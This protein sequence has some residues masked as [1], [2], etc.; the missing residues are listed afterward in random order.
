MAQRATSLGPKPSLFVF[1]VFLCLFFVLFFGCLIQN[2]KPCFSPRKGLFYL[3]SVFLFLSPLCPFGPP[4][5]SVSLSQ[6]LFFLLFFLSSFL[7][8]VLAFFWFLVFVSFFF[9]LSFFLF[10][11]CFSFMKGTTSKYSIASFFGLPSFSLF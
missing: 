3:F 6:S 11:L 10:L 4:S 1:L 2:Q 7:V 9:F 5:F 8:F